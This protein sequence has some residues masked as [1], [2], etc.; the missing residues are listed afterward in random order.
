MPK[1]I[2]IALFCVIMAPLGL[3]LWWEF[4]RSR[5]VPR[6]VARA[7]KRHLDTESAARHMAARKETKR[8]FDAWN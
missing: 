5:G 6:S 4:R 2:I 3:I 8:G 7:F 1:G